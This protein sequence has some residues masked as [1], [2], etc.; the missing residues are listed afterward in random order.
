M[1]TPSLEKPA[2]NSAKRP[3]R[4]GGGNL[5]VTQIRDAIVSSSASRYNFAPLR[6]AKSLEVTGDSHFV[7]R[8]G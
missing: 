5:T 8:T 3:G 1:P 4:K 7:S 2:P 6:Y